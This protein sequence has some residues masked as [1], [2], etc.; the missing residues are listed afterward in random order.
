M[1][2]GILYGS[3]TKDAGAWSND[4]IVKEVMERKDIPGNISKDKS[5]NTAEDDSYTDMIVL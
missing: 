2:S 1:E 3:F 5:T 4:A